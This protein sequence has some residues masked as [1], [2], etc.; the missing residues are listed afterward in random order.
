MQVIKITNVD[1]S[2]R[3]ST[4]LVVYDAAEIPKGEYGSVLWT[5]LCLKFKLPQF[6]Q[7]LKGLEVDYIGDLKNKIYFLDEQSDCV[8]IYNPFNHEGQGIIA[9][10]ELK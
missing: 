7:L 5:A 6:E 10:K 4:A 2:M 1:L 9:Y 3:D 8:T